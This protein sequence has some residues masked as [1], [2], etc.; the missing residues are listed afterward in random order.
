M[1]PFTKAEDSGGRRRLEAK[2]KF[3]LDHHEVPLRHKMSSGQ[4]DNMHLEFIETAD[5]ETRI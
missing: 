2:H 3:S 5:P 1:V 4:L